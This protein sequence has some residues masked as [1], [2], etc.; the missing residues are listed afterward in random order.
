MAKLSLSQATQRFQENDERIDAFANGDENGGYVSSGG[1]AVPSISKF[2]AQKNTDINNGA[3]SILAASNAARDAAQTSATN[4]AASAASA[5]STASSIASQSAILNALPT[6]TGSSNV[7]FK[8][9]GTGA[10]TRT[11]ESKLKELISPIDFEAKGDGINDDTLALNRWITAIKNSNA[12]GYVPTG[13]YRI[14]QASLG[15]MFVGLV[16]RTI[17]FNRAVF[18]VLDG[19]PVTGGQAGFYFKNCIDCDFYGFTLDGNRS[20]RTPAEVYSHNVVISG[21]M[22]RCK[23]WSCRSINAVCDPWIIGPDLVNT[24]SDYPTDIH[25]HDC[26]GINAY[27]NGLSV[28]GSLRLRVYGGSFSGANGTLPMSGIDVE[29]NADTVF[30]NDSYEFINVE[31]SD[32]YGYGIQ[33][34]GP[35]DNPRGRLVNHSGKSNGQGIINVS[36][37]TGLQIIS[38]KCGPHSTST[39]GLID[40]SSTAIDVFIDN[41]DFKDITASGGSVCCIY[42]HQLSTGTQI[43]RIRAKAISCPVLS[44]FGS[45]IIDGAT[46]NGSTS[47]SPVIG[48]SGTSRYNKVSNIYVNGAVNRALYVS[49]PNT[50]IIN[51][52]SVDCSL[53]GGFG[54]IDIDTTGTGSIIRG[55]KISQTSG[56]VPSGQFGIR[57]QC[58]MNE[59]SGVHGIGGYTASN[60]IS[61][62]AAFSKDAKIF[63]INPDPLKVL[64]PNSGKTFPVGLQY[65]AQASIPIASLGDGVLVCADISGVPFMYGVVTA[66]GSIAYYSVNNTASGLTVGAFNF[67]VSVVKQ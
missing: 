66:T 61:I 46:V 19:D 10:A 58:A 1:A 14:S 65:Q 36:L 62:T 18:K 32:N 42:V 54:C 15:V 23:F 56:T 27:R 47:T 11:V 60:V 67:V 57:A 30:G 44:A 2:L 59:I 50:E 4:S 24:L 17:R 63:G 52:T 28:I 41:P 37:A 22:L 12:D 21:G 49:S 51:V 48:I 5:A 8:Q 43:S 33:F 64:I 38:P 40:V 20:A 55:A 25:L 7:G 34:G 35:V 53:T 26:E 39:R 6:A 31:T 13:T 9:A 16:G 29:P 45:I 3:S